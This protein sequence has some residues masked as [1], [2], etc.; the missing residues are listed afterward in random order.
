[1]RQI[2]EENSGKIM[3]FIINFES[4]YKYLYQKSK[5]IMNENSRLCIDTMGKKSGQAAGLSSCHGLG[6]NQVVLFGNN[7]CN[8]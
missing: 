8:Y 7:E 3:N 2:F 6:G 4:M 1:V 5:Q